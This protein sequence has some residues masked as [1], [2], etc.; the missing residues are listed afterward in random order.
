MTDR[1]NL[2]A[3]RIPLEANAWANTSRSGCSGA[4]LALGRHLRN[5][6]KGAVARCWVCC[7]FSAPHRGGPERAA[8]N[9]L[10]NE[11]VFTVF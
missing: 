10:N 5:G 7:H 2:R 4:R 3:A 1:C 6:E 8:P 11:K 9:I